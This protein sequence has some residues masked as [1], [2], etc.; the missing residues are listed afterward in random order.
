MIFIG[1]VIMILT[2]SILCGIAA[3]SNQLNVIVKHQN[4]IIKNLKK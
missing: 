1:I 3:I 2:F 4:E